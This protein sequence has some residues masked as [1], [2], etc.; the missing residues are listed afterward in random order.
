MKSHGILWYTLCM[1]NL[2]NEENYHHEGEGHL[3]K[4]NIGYAR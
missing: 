3:L 1:T 4:L 2:K